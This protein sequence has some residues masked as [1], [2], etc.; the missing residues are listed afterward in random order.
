MGAA[1]PVEAGELSDRPLQERAVC[2]C[3]D[4]RSA[5]Q[6]VT[7]EI[8]HLSSALQDD[9]M[10]RKP[11]VIVHSVYVGRGTGSLCRKLRG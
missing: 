1:A 9:R 6:I 7:P 5:V 2:Q 11:Y 3:A 4:Q 10:A 8:T